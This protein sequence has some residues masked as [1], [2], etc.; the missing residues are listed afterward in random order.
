MSLL[1]PGINSFS[2]L[3]DDQT[4]LLS[5]VDNSYIDMILFVNKTDSSIQI[6]LKFI[7]VIDV[8]DPI[9]NFLAWNLTIPQGESVNV[10]A[11]YNL[12]LW[13]GD[14]DSL[15]SFSNGYNQTYDCTLTYRR[16]KV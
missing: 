11:K 14:T 9:E 12:V 8:P 15:I 3:A 13:L 6:N 4:V 1:I 7:K 16:M 10:V 5:S 2:D